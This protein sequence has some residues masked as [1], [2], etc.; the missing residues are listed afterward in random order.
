MVQEFQ[1]ESD[2]CVCVLYV[3]VTVSIVPVKKKKKRTNVT[4][5]CIGFFVLIEVLSLKI[6]IPVLSMLRR[7]EGTSL[8]M[9][10]RK[11][12]LNKKQPSGGCSSYTLA[13]LCHFRGAM[14]LYMY[15]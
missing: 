2:G 12:G 3:C 4:S 7:P 11:K 9:L 14:L 10:E 1:V 15:L 8:K 13:M 5:N 6:Q